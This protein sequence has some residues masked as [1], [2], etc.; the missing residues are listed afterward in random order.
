MACIAPNPQPTTGGFR[1]IGEAADAAMVGLCRRIIAN[2]NNS[3]S[4]KVQARKF[5]SERGFSA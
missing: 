1:Q 5:L 2:P 4:G 3:E